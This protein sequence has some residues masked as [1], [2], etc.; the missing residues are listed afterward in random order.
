MALDA[1]F[2]IKLCCV[3]H[4]QHLS[5]F[6]FSLLSSGVAVKQVLYFNLVVTSLGTGE[7]ICKYHLCLSSPQLF[8][9]TLQ[10][11]VGKRILLSQ[12]CR[13]FS[14]GIF[15]IVF[16][17]LISGIEML[18]LHYVCLFPLSLVYSPNILSQNPFQGKPII[19]FCFYTLVSRRG[20]RPHLKISA[21][22]LHSKIHF[23]KL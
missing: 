20:S 19:V 14:I 6:F 21:T 12:N 16:L 4:L 7:M 1:G 5:F 17:L 2:F 22:I 15:S 13:C 10:L 3:S 18:L 9:R 23:K 8:F 11:Q